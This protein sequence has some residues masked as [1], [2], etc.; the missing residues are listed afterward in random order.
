MLRLPPIEFK[1][2][3][4]ME[5]V[6]AALA[7]D[8][9]R[10]VAGGTDLWPNMKRRHQQAKTVVSLMSIPELRGIEQAD[11]DLRVGATTTLTDVVRDEGIR[12]RYPAFARAPSQAYS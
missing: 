10:L 7:G 2:A 11:G 12:T 9:V 4:R 3:R 8:E 1:T 6:L 5:D